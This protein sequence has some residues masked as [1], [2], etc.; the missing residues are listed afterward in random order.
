MIHAGRFMLCA[1]LL[2]LLASAA[3]AQEGRKVLLLNGVW[4]VAE[5]SMDQIPQRFDHHVVVPGLVDMAEPAFAE[6]GV[7]SKLRQA[8]WYRRTFDL[9]GPIPAAARLKVHKAAY[10]SRVYLNGKLLDDHL[11]SYTPGYFD[12]RQALRQGANELVIRVG[13]FRDSVPATVPAGWDYEKIK[14]IPGIFDTVELLL[15]ATPY[16][17]N[18]QAAPDLQKQTVSVQVTLAN[19]GPKAAALVKLTVQP[20]KGGAIAGEGQSDTVSIEQG[21]TAQVMVQVPIADCRLWSPEDPFLYSL[22]ASTG[23]DELAVRFGMRSFKFDQPTGRAVLNGKPYF[24][25]GTNV[26]LYR[27][28]EDPQRGDKPWSTDW[29][30][31]LHQAY[32]TM[33]WNSIR[34]CIGFPPE[35]W[36]DIADET[37]F[38]IQDEFPVWG[39]QGD[40]PAYAAQELTAEYTEWMQERWN[41]PCVV[42]WDAQNETRLPAT[43]Q[44]IQAVRGLD[45][46]HRPFDNGWSPPQDPGDCFESHPYLFSDANFKLRDLAR[47]SGVPGG[48][49]LPNTGK[50]AIVINEY[51]W[52]WLNRDG[53]TTTL[54]RQVY[55]NLLGASATPEQRRRLRARYVAALTEF[56]RCHRACAGVLH[57]CG[58]GYSRPGGQ[59]SDDFVDLD[60]LTFEENFRTHVGEAFAPVGLMI[61]RWDDEMPAGKSQEFP[62]VVINDLQRDYAGQV[63]FRLLKGSQV[64]QE[65]VRQCQVAALGQNRLSFSCSIPAEPAAYQ[66]EAALLQ[67]GEAP[68]RSLRDFEILTE[69][70]LAQRRGLAVGKPVKVSSVATRDGQTYAAEF[71]V[72]GRP[73]TRWSSE[74]S[75]PQWITVDLQRAQ[76]IARVELSWEGAYGKAYNIE[77]SLDGQNWKEVYKTDAGKGGVETIRFQPVETR[78]IRLTGTKRATPY[79]YSLWEFKV[80]GQ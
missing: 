68:V 25:R 46:S 51:D 18:I 22:Q 44:A 2:L 42:I 62:V 52:L 67:P 49:P 70:Q 19:N 48:N 54:T 1:S 66:V 79:G 56:W 17:V 12:A 50:N 40:R 53:S 20:A 78:F 6:V 35:I 21:G 77:V 59:T 80:F 15:T 11:G 9:A 16:I 58:L 63:R 45:L 26:T 31:R 57:F 75:D 7:Q 24:M 4:E 37:G 5:G 47:V 8:F 65:T 76:S 36:Y 30:R 13:A 28:F 38:L 55:Q 14:Y 23:T 29:V 43:G 71:A 73:D 39:A 3:Q 60:K 61:D 74:F 72:D 41:H 27:F 33:H 69:Q 34:Y 32:Q 10:G 64:V